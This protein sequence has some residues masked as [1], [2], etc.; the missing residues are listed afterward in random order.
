MDKHDMERLESPPKS[1]NLSIIETWVHSLRRKFFKRRVASGEA[2]VHRFYPVWKE[3]DP[4]TI[5]KTINAYP[6]RLHDCI[7]VYKEAMTK[8]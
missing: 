5:N 6:K 8:Y 2:G 7:K 1:P 4:K 3:L